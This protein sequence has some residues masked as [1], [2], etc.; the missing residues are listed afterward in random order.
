MTIENQ[1]DKQVEA[2]KPAEA[3]PFSVELPTFVS[4]A[5]EAFDDLDKDMNHYLSPDELDAKG[6][7]GIRKDLVDSLSKGSELIQGMNDDEWGKDNDGITRGDLYRLEHITYVDRKRTDSCKSAARIFPEVDLSMA[8][9]NDQPV[10]SADELVE[11][12]KQIIEE[13]ETPQEKLK[14]P[15]LGTQAGFVRT[16]RSIDSST[17]VEIYSPRGVEYLKLD[18]NREVTEVSVYSFTPNESLDSTFFDKDGRAVSRKRIA[19]NG[20]ESLPFD[21]TLTVKTEELGS[22]GTKISFDGADK[23]S[24]YSLDVA[25]NLRVINI[26]SQSDGYNQEFNESG[27]PTNSIKTSRDLHGNTT[28]VQTIGSDG[29]RTQFFDDLG[30]MKQEDFTGPF[31]SSKTYYKKDGSFMG[32]SI[33]SQGDFTMTTP[34]PTVNR[35]RTS[36]SFNLF[37]G[38]HSITSLSDVYGSRFLRSKWGQEKSYKSPD[39]HWIK[40][41]SDMQLRITGW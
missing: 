35:I 39:G 19:K 2:A 7:I 24:E 17:S 28:E 15:Q 30:F 6:Q 33:N 8:C 36:N 40:R 12:I 20:M 31:E 38:E 34:D 18:D 5:T 37:T 23:D 32:Y 21:P 16:V 29:T 14:V 26:E 10:S 11:K 13:P 3:S 1:I 27:Y 22:L 25:S 41:F 4:K 9:S